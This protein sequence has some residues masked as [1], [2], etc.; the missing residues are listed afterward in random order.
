MLNIISEVVH[1]QYAQ[2]CTSLTVIFID[3]LNDPC[4]IKE[5]R[6]HQKYLD[7][8]KLYIINALQ[9]YIFQTILNT[10]FLPFYHKVWGVPCLLQ[11]TVC[12]VW[13][14]Q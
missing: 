5:Y 2:G 13:L 3:L 7:F 8:G 11:D 4:H 14:I 9:L 1:H 10:I 12:A 6:L